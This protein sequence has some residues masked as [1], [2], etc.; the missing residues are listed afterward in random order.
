MQFVIVH[1]FLPMLSNAVYAFDM[2]IITSNITC[3][4]FMPASTF[5][6]RIFT[7]HLLA[8]VTMQAQRVAPPDMQCKDKFLIQ[9]TVVPYGT[10]E[11]DIRSDMVRIEGCNWF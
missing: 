9:S 4:S 10:T 8:T 7:H 5:H 3:I 1:L 2:V 6:N 11:T